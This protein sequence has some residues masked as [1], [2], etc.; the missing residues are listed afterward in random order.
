MCRRHRQYFEKMLQ[1]IEVNFVN[2]DIRNFYQEVKKSQL[3]YPM[4][5][6]YYRDD[7]GRLVGYI[8]GKLDIW[9]DYSEK[10]LGG[11]MKKM[12]ILDR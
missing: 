7:N 10:L 12:F 8:N 2:K 4:K 1:E 11:S 5:T 9:P 6:V 3:S